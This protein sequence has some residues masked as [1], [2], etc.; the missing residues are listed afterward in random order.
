MSRSATGDTVYIK[1]ANNIYTVLA[2]AAL[3]VVILGLVAIYLRMDAL[4]ILQAAA[5]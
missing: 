3:V 2:G 4:G 1:P 5:K